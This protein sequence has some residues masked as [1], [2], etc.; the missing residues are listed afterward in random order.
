MGAYS[1]VTNSAIHHGL[2]N[3]VRVLSSNNVLLANNTVYDHYTYGINVLSSSN[4]TVDGNL[5]GMVHPSGLK[6]SD[7]VIPLT[8]GIVM[9]GAEEGD[10]CTDIFALNN[11]VSGSTMVGFVAPGH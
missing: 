6:S 9:C 7:H 10:Y 5:V 8:G 1:Q 3:G 4:I 2:G 11:I